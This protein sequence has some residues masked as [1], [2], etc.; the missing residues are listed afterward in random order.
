MTRAVDSMAAF[1]AKAQAES[2]FAPAAVATS[3]ALRGLL[4]EDA[5]VGGVGIGDGRD[6]GAPDELGLLRPPMDGAGGG[7]SLTAAEMAQV[8]GRNLMGFRE[9]FGPSQQVAS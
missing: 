6:W 7:G 2:S 3:L 9:K 1:I 8:L 4:V 5:G